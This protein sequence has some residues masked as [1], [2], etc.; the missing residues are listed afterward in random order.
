MVVDV[1]SEAD[2]LGI[3]GERA[4]DVGD[5]QW[6]NFH[7]KH[8]LSSRLLRT[9]SKCQFA[10]TVPEG[11]SPTAIAG[12]STLDITHDLNKDGIPGPRGGRW[13]RTVPN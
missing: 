6:N 3:K 12:K 1:Q 2:P 10:A 11:P 8:S 13:D 7:G 5:R 9:P 4:V